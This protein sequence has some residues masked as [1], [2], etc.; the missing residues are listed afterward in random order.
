MLESPP[1]TTAAFQ[2]FIN[3]RVLKGQYIWFA[4][5]KDVWQKRFEE[6]DVTLH[7]LHAPPEILAKSPKHVIIT[8]EYDDVRWQTDEYAMKLNKAGVLAD[9]VVLPGAVH[10]AVPMAHGKVLVQ[11]VQ[12][13]L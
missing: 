3:S 12:K 5:G 8:G 4:G 11:A 10:M 1:E 2:A 6:K 9:Y 7:C 13:Y